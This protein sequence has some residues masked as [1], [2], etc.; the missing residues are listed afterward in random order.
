MVGNRPRFDWRQCPTG[1]ELIAGLIIVGV[2]DAE[3]ENGGSTMSTTIQPAIDFDLTGC[4]DS[5]DYS[6]DFDDINFG[7]QQHIYFYNI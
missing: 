5:F 1:P 6:F 4:T 2:D 7:E 3:N